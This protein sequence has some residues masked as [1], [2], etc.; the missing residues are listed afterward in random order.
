MVL[1]IK[2]EVFYPRT[3]I[4]QNIVST[5]SFVSLNLAMSPLN[6]A[7]KTDIYSGVGKRIMVP[8]APRLIYAMEPEKE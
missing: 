4:I 5:T 8:E 1:S 6:L 3:Y 2:H 7:V